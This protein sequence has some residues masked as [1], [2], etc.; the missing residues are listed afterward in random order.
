[1]CVC[2]TLMTE[3]YWKQKKKPRRKKIQFFIRVLF[4]FLLLSLNSF[5]FLFQL[6]Y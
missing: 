3:K 6:F 1:M 4:S 2:A 5:L